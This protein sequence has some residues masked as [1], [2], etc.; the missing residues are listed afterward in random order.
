M[1]FGERPRYTLRDNSICRSR[2]HLAR[3]LDILELRTMA[4]MFSN[5]AGSSA[6]AE[7]HVLLTV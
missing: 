4:G 2:G 3:F 5:T 1:G 6:M 7:L